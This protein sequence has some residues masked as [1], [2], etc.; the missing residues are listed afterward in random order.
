M[1]GPSAG[2]NKN[3]P[4]RRSPD[5]MPAHPDSGPSMPTTNQEHH[6]T[7]SITPIQDNSMS[8]GLPASCHASIP[9][10]PLSLLV[11]WTK[12]HCVLC[13]TKLSLTRAA[14]QTSHTKCSV[15]ALANKVQYYQPQTVP[16]QLTTR[17][18]TITYTGA[19]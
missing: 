1:A 4:N 10:H 16:F 14:P 11:K 9:S 5:L 2:C 18:Q 17:R 8:P 7:I 13:M 6:Q 3:T 12:L 19:F 15:M